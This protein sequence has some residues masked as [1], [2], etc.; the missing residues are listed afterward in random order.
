MKTT[1]VHISDEYDVYIGRENARLRLPRSKWANPFPIC[2]GRTRQQSI[3]MYRNWIVTQVH[4]MASLH[5]LKGKRLGCW[6]H[7]KE[8][9]GDFLA[10]M[11]DTLIPGD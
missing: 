4:L 1:V 5:E 2:T 8:C 7:P 11:V 6:C 3:Q 10:A 9:H